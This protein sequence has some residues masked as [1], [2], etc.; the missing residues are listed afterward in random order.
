MNLIQK[1]TIAYF[2]FLTVD[3]TAQTSVNPAQKRTQEQNNLFI[4]RGG[5]YNHYKPPSYPRVDHMRICKDTLCQ[6]GKETCGKD[7]GC[8]ISEESKCIHRSLEY[9]NE[10]FVDSGCMCGVKSMTFELLCPRNTWCQKF[11]DK[12][13]CD[14]LI[15]KTGEKCREKTVDVPKPGQS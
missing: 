13:I 12:T 9:G 11:N 4:S 2:I 8:H 7:V 5:R 6:C 10:C 14:V 1:I 3:C 15:I